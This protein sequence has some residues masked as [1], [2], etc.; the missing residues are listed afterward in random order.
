MRSRKARWRQQQRGEAAAGGGDDRG[1]A[2]SRISDGF[3]C[4]ISLV[5]GTNT[6][7]T[8]QRVVTW[9]ACKHDKTILNM[10][11]KRGRRRNE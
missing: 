2:L 5:K 8:E 4:Q 9:V 1:P 3:H 11:K 7:Q 6:C 10:A